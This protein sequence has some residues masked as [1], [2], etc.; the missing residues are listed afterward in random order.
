M[1]IESGA[2]SALDPNRPVTVR[3][4]VDDDLPNLD[5]SVEGVTTVNPE[6]TFWDKVVIVHGLRSWFEMRGEL[7]GGGQRVT[8]HYY[9]LH[10]LVA[11]E[12][13]PTAAADLALGADCVAHAQMFFNSPDLDLASAPA[14]ELRARPDNGD[15]GAACP[16][17]SSHERDDLRTGAAFRRGHGDRGRARTAAERSRRH[18]DHR[19]RL[20][21]R[22]PRRIEDLYLEGL[23]G[24]PGLHGRRALGPA[25]SS[26][27]RLM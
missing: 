11:S 14:R 26:R 17:L 27:V 13:G 3:P 16:R 1:K 8:R 24:R 4:Y 12:M 19:P 20:S 7:R 23:L 18:L 22:T 2:K 21:A 15:A 10:R 5:L 9:D 6:R 25:A